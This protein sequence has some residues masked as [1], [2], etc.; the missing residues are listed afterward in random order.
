MDRCVL[1]EAGEEEVDLL[2]DV[3]VRL[4]LRQSACGLLWFGE[5][6]AEVCGG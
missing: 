4:A 5:V 2:C 1:G 3:L 6:R